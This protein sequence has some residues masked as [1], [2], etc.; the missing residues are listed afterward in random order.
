[1]DR[2]YIIIWDSE[3]VHRDTIDPLLLA[4]LYTS[5]SLL[6]NFF[7]LFFFFFVI[8]FFY[9]CIRLLASFIT[10]WLTLH[11]SHHLQRNINHQTGGRETNSAQSCDDG[12]VAITD[13]ALPRCTSIAIFWIKNWR[14]LLSPACSMI[15]KPIRRTNERVLDPQAPR[16]S[17]QRGEKW[18]VVVKLE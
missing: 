5:L 9:F 12:M 16:V 4:K 8:S 17:T 3:P 10:R 13:A 14:A 1:M 11:L 7:L 6:S 15:R 18:K 2:F